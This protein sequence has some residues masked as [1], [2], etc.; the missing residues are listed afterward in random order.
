MILP[1]GQV[2]F[3]AGLLSQF[4]GEWKQITSDPISLQA[5]QGVKIPLKCT[6]PLCCAGSEELFSRISDPVVDS[7]IQEMLALNAIQVVD[8]KTE[9]FISRVFTVPKLERGKEYG[10]RFILNL[11][12]SIRLLLP[13]YESIADLLATLLDICNLGYGTFAHIQHLPNPVNP[14]LSST[15]NSYLIIV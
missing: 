5:L 7:T 11:K 4:M 6:P 12:V 14:I 9:V 1:T 3:Q 13:F 15:F 8:R 10:R 2:P